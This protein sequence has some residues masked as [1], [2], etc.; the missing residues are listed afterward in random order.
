MGSESEASTRG[1]GAVESG[2]ISELVA[3][4]PYDL[5]RSLSRIVCAVVARRHPEAGPREQLLETG[6]FP[7]A[8]RSEDRPV[9]VALGQDRVDGPVDLRV[10]AA[11]A[12]P[13]S[14]ALVAE[15]RRILC[16]DHDLDD[17]YRKAAE[18]PVLADL[19]RRYRGLRLALTPTPFQGLCH[20]ILFQQVSYLAAQ[21]TEQRFKERFGDRLE[22]S[23][24]TFWLSP[25]PGRVAS[26]SE[27]AL[28]SVGI[29]FRKGLAML[30]VAR[31]IVQ[32]RLDLA[33]LVLEPD[34]DVAAR[35]LTR[36]FGIG[37]WTAHHAMIRALGV[38]DCLPYEDPGLRSAV[39]LCYRLHGPASAEDVREIAERWRP[40]RSYA[41]YYFWNTF[42]EPAA[43]APSAGATIAPP[44]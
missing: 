13:R 12:T 42:W 38:T 19:V 3:R 44:D 11:D 21:T 22:H 33:A 43:P 4:G 23:G 8:L 15:V 31:E 5:V 39:T 29:P 20:A 37:P 26:L 9:L 18:D 6:E 25:T 10:L 32:G 2:K 16:L 34:A 30:T 7:M 35:R 14:E 27:D 36:Y 17:W 28:R 41:A 24:R 40:W 1:Q